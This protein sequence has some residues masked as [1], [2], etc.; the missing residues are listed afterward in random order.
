MSK[1]GLSFFVM[2]LLFG[3]GPCLSSCGP[4]LVSYFAGRRKSLGSGLVFY[5]LFSSGRIFVYL[6][7]S[8]ALFFFGRLAVENVFFRRFSKYIFILSAAF[9]VFIGAALA[10]GGERLKFCRPFYS[11][12]IEK[13]KKSAFLLG[14]F[15]GLIPCAP[16]FAVFSY[17][18]LISRS[19]G[20]AFVSSLSFGLGTILSPL[21]LMA[22]M[23]GAIP[24]FLLKRSKAAEAAFNLICGLIIVLLGLRLGWKAFNA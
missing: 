12:F 4:L 17:A 2:G 11:N 9:L 19:L 15:A 1:A 23:A 24:G 21:L 3:S 13:D 5:L 16:L 7:L 6:F 8:L 10:T 14:F 22:L 18:G 20:L